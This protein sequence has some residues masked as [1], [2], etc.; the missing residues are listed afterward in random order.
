MPG[1]APPQTRLLGLLTQV[2]LSGILCTQHKGLPERLHGT[3]Y[4]ASGCPTTI[5]PGYPTQERGIRM[6]PEG[7][8][9][10]APV[11]MSTSEAGRRGGSV[12][13]D[14]YGEDYYRRIGKKGGTALKQKRGS[15]Y[16]RDIARKGGQANV[17]KYGTSHFSEMGKKGGNTTKERQDSDFYSRIGKMGGAA[18]RQRKTS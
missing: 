14:K 4:A 12:V 2:E 15:E 6:E 11:P 9:K 17:D 1:Q 18:K 8:V 16:Y 13:R 10:P 7:E 5:S 3:L